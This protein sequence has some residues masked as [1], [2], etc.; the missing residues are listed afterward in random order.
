VLLGALVAIAGCGGGNREDGFELPSQRMVRVVPPMPQMLA[1]ATAARIAVVRGDRIVTLASIPVGQTLRNLQWSGD[2][3]SLAWVLM[4]RRSQGRLVVHD[5]R[6][7]EHHAW[8]GVSAYGAPA[9]SPHGVTIGTWENG[10]VEYR[11]D[12]TTRKYAVE[13]PGEDRD[14]DPFDL[15]LD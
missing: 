9:P 1:F 8:S 4:D 5:L 12:G 11:A 7:G 2:G 6:S 3:A 13:V 10:F 14:V 15:H